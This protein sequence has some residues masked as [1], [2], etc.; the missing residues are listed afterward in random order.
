MP[1]K[2]WSGAHYISAFIQMQRGSQPVN[3]R[4]HTLHNVHEIA[5]TGTIFPNEKG[6]PIVHM[7]MACGR[8]TNT[9][10]G[11]IRK[12]VKTWHVLEVIL[13]ELT[14]IDSKRVLVPFTGFELLQP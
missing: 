7:H 12:G 5:G 6:E 13:Y 3:P 11:C 2:F 4:E 10:T 14:D 9:V 8:N 1:V